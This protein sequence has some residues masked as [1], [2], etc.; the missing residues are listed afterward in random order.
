MHFVNLL[1]VFLTVIPTFSEPVPKP[2]WTELAPIGRG[3]RQ[4]ESVT[5]LGTDM[6]IIGGI[7]QQPP[8]PTLD[9]VEVFSVISNKW[10]NAAPLPITI[11]HGNVATVDGKIH[12]LGGLNGSIDWTAIGN[13][14]EYDPRNDTWK[15]LPSMPNGTE[16]GASAVGVYGSTVYLAGGLTELNLITG[17]QPTVDTVTSYNTKTQ[18]WTTLPS[19]PEGRD[20]VGGVV[21]GNIFYVVGG[22]VNGIP[23]VRNTIFAM[24]IT[25]PGNGWVQKAIMPTARGGLST[26]AIG[27]RIY[28]FGGEGSPALVPNGVYDNVEVYDTVSDTWET[29]PPMPFPRHGTNAASI[30]TRIHIPGGGNVTGAGAQAINDFYQP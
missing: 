20:H 25:C 8:Y 7:P 14:Y 27:T 16:R 29:L 24:D 3:P 13:C 12:I 10:R 5:A 6:Y 11:N 18:R 1:A 22:R 23:N 26:S 28:T 15:T 19:L 9:W 4:E 30:G 2:G 17:A 21:I